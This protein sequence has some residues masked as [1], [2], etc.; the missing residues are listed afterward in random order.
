MIVSVGPKTSCSSW[1]YA[2][3]VSAW[4][5]RDTAANPLTKPSSPEETSRAATINPLKPAKIDP[6]NLAALS[7]VLILILSVS[8][9]DNAAKG[10]FTAV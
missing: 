10:R 7:L 1:R 3:K 5:R 4:P 9:V 8:S 2:T 6:V